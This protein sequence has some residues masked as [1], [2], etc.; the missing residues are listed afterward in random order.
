MAAKTTVKAIAYYGAIS[1]GVGVMNSGLD[2][3]KSVYN[4][5][6]YC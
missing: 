1:G 2:I 5:K 6:C 4:H 3:G